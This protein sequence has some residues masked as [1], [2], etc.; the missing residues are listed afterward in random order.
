METSS[1]STLRRSSARAAAVACL[2]S[3]AGSASAGYPEDLQLGTPATADELRAIA[4]AVRPDG[5]GL[6][7]GSGDWT[8]GNKVYEAQCAAC[9]GANLQ[10]VAGFP[11]MPSGEALRLV[12]GRG[13]LTTSKPVQSVESYLPYATTLFDYIRRA[14]PFHAPG[15]L[16]NDEV[17]AVSAYILA[18]AKIIG[19][20]DVMSA[21]TLPLV[22]MPNRDGFV[23]DNRPEH[24]KLK[25]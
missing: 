1:S 4:I 5:K 25:K 23:Q 17:Y 15:S 10:G 22:K 7:A 14:M 19:R 20:T 21:R 3:V 16:S 8:A 12:G 9:N 2:A 6:P 11:A 24:F 13:T 18:E